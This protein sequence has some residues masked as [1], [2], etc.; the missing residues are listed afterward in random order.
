MA[1]FSLHEHLHHAQATQ[2]YNNLMTVKNAHQTGL[3][4]VDEAVAYQMEKL[5]KGGL[6]L[7]KV[8]MPLVRSSHKR[9]REL[10]LEEAMERNAQSYK[11]PLPSPSLGSADIDEPQKDAG[12]AKEDT[13]GNGGALAERIKAYWTN[14]KKLSKEQRM[15][16]K[17]EIEN[18]LT[19]GN[20]K[21]NVPLS[22]PKINTT[23]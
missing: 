3:N 14:K 10:A 9:K 17:S 19:G 16:E 4:N 13:G 22:T 12:S 8:L 20:K 18:A 7:E 2:E 15:K 21:A 23:K 1:N 11:S 6:E 5:H